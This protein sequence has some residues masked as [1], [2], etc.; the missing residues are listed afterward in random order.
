MLRDSTQLQDGLLDYVVQRPMRVHWDIT[1][2]GDERDLS[3]GDVIPGE[4]AESWP[5]RAVNNLMW[6]GRLIAV[7]RGSAGEGSQGVGVAA[8]PVTPEFPRDLGGGVFE[9]SDQSRA[10]GKIAAL[11]AQAELD[12]KADATQSPPDP[13]D[14]P[15]ELVEL[16]GGFYALS[17]GTKVR[18]R[19]KALAAQAELDAAGA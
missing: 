4:I 10:D 18:G 3:V 11:A 19:N 8:E 9:L 5:G 7:P 1:V 15:F 6:V 13:D 14:A 17:D 16:G 12:A 2:A